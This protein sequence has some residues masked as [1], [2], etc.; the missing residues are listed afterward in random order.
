MGAHIWVDAK[1]DVGYFSFF[2]SQLVD[3]FE[4]GDTL[5][6]E[7]EDAFVQSE[8][9]FPVGFAHP[10]IYNL[11][12]SKPCFETTAYL[13]AAYA[14]CSQSF[15]SD[16]VQHF[17]VGIGLDS[18]VHAEAFV[19]A[20]LLLDDLYGLS[21]QFCVVIVE[22]CLQLLKFFDREYSF[23][24]SGLLLLVEQNIAKVL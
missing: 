22:G 17:G 13:A 18:I 14:V 23:H 6:I 21:E 9:D 7:A 4:F 5:H 3:Y 12:G 20:S 16:N 19:F 1:A 8:V 10:G 15:L 24:A 2:T 11:L